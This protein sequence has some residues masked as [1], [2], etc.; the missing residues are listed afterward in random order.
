M[1]VAEKHHTDWKPAT[2]RWSSAGGPALLLLIFI[3]FFW[4]LLLTNQYTWLDNPDIAN[5]VLP[6]YQFQ[7]G[8]WHAGR[9]PLWDPYLWGGQ[10]LVGQMQ[11][12][13]AYPPNWLL[14]LAPLR[15][16]WIRQ[17]YLHWYF[18]L[19]HF[20]GALFCYWLCRDL[21][22]SRAASLLAG[23]AFGLGGFLGTNGWP[24]MLNGAVWAPLVLLFFLRAMRGERT[25][26]SAAWSGAFLGIA[27]LSGHHQIPIFIC[28][29]MGGAWL[30]YL[31]TEPALRIQRFRLLLIFSLFLILL[32]SFQTLPAA[33]YARHALRWV[34]AERPV[35]WK[36]T[37]PYSVHQQYSF[38][39][40]SLLG[41]VIPGMY[42]NSDPYVG[43][44]ALT[45]A[46]FG[47]I[48]AWDDR[49][50]RLFASIAIGG[51][52]YSLG[53]NSIFHGVLYAL[54][55]MVDKARSPSMAT[56]IFHFGLCI[57]IAY[58]VDYYEFASKAFARRAAILL[59]GLSAVVAL[60]VW[61]SSVT[62]TPADDRLG[63]VMLA[64][65]FLA[66]ALVAWNNARISRLA[67]VTMLGLLILFELG[68]VTT[69][70]YQLRG[71][72]ESLIKPLSEHA[73]I[74]A[75]LRD[76]GKPVRVEVNENDIPYNF[77]DWYGIDHFGGYLASMT[78]NVDRVQGNPRARDMYGVNFQIGK[79][80]SRPGQVQV[81][82]G[83]SGI[84]VYSEP[85]A[86]PRAWAVHDAVSIQ[87]DDQINAKMDDPAFDP[88]RQTFVEGAVP[89]LASC[90]EPEME[91]VALTERLPE[92]V[93]I[94]ANLR[95]RGMVIVSDTYFPGW[96]ATVDGRPATIYEAYGFLRGVVVEGGRHRI[97]MR[98]RPRSVYW[99]AALSL[100]GLSGACLLT[101]WQRRV[102]VP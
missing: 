102:A 83:I 81:F 13:A 47:V 32:S 12:G 3:C 60:I 40:E 77:G 34:G 49:M 11:P 87:R 19:I 86:F 84:K 41:I 35:G 67:A 31:L 78:E 85:S 71:R 30:Y 90:P 24:V 45:L 25:V 26:S 54:V 2:L 4:K 10:P 61:V 69:Y 18:V 52:L 36:D 59:C 8:E 99:G 66:A 46:L 21:K 28:L 14:F 20:Q 5:Q 68:N 43:L 75:F 44:A 63:I 93:K 65:L 101:A 62:K 33:E 42:R 37:V 97:E 53:H 27:F 29:T 82:Q 92:G 57:L 38:Y 88:R 56:F 89:Q 73:D 55:P 23:L 76:Q 100:I 80:P 70:T 17:S 74:A 91:I 39:P 72:A 6:W 50:T 15:R 48:A 98:Y 9:M 79:A 22:R 96:V 51:L 94:D 1:Q 58:G 64:G 16:G 95:C 7:A